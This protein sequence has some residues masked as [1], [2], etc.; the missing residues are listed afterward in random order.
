[1]R[2]FNTT[3][4]NL[5]ATLDDLDPLVD[6]SKPV[7]D[8]LGPFF[9][10]FRAASADLVPTVRDLDQIVE[11]PGHG[12]RPRRP[13]P[14]AADAWRRSP[15]GPSTATASS[16]RAPCPSR[17][18]A[19]R[20]SLDELAFFR[21]YSPELTG[22]FDDFGHSGVIDANG[23]IGRIGTTFNTF[24]LGANDLP[25]VDLAGL[26]KQSADEQYSARPAT[27]LDIGNY[28]RCPGSNERPAPDGSNP[29]TRRRLDA[30][31]PSII[32]PGRI[33][34][35]RSSSA[36]LICASVAGLAASAAVTTSTPTSS[37]STTPSG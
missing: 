19:L 9:R 22:W 14:P 3:A 21:A 13:D 6:A 28:K 20:D 4:V 5:R 33:E 18:T 11:D 35:A 27:S 32:P 1:M 2:N 25:I 37:S 7:A 24:S 12:Q 10:N 23:G 29:W 16:A 31:D 36:A 30:C 15:S 8:R 34:T 26:L 17:A